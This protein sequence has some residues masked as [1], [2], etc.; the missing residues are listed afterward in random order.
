MQQAGGMQCVC[1]D[2]MAATCTLPDATGSW[3]PLL[4]L[5]ALVYA[6]GLR[7]DDSSSDDED[8][9]PSAMYS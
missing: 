4:L 5:L 8:Q 2:T 3:T 6:L 9:P 7:Q 1:S